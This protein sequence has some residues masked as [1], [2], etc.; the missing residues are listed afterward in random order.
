MPVSALEGQ[1]THF[2]QQR[3]KQKKTRRTHVQ[4]RIQVQLPP[5]QT[6]LFHC[7]CNRQWKH[8]IPWQTQGQA[9]TDRKLIKK[10]LVIHGCVNTSIPTPV[11]Y[12][13]SDSRHSKNIVWPDVQEKPRTKLLIMST[14]RVQNRNKKLHLRKP[15]TPN[16]TKRRQSFSVWAS[17]LHKPR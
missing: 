13:V 2:C 12:Y 15:T 14:I 10:V 4:T 16:F 8:Q 1:E 17:V 3:T 11:F 7:F 5:R 6:V 9:E